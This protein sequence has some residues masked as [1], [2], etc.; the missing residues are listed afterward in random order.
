MGSAVQQTLMF[1]VQ[2]AF[3]LYSF[4]I[5]LRLWLRMA[6]ADYQHPFVESIARSTTPV[7]RKLQKYMP[8]IGKF[9]VASFVLL[10]AVTLVKLLLVSLISGHA[11]QLAGLLAWTLASMLEVVL[12]A[13]FYVMIMMAILS[14]LPNAHPALYGLLMQIT[15]PL[16]MPVRRYVPLLGGMDLSPVIVLVVIQVIEMLMLQPLIRASL[17]ATF[18]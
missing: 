16:L 9:E 3:G 5:V 4:V 12:D 1:I 15:I 6:D 7:V 13:A 17:S 14:W 10:F 11:P 18:R 8:N 2:F